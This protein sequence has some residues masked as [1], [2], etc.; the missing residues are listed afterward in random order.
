[1]FKRR[2]TLI[3]CLS[4]RLVILLCPLLPNRLLHRL[5]KRFA[6]FF[7]PARATELSR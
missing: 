6:H 3:P 5:M 4:D 1:M 7:E 2:A